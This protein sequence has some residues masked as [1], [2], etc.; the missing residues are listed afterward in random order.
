MGSL[1]WLT[2]CAT[3]YCWASYSSRAGG[4]CCVADCCVANTGAAP[5]RYRRSLHRDGR[6]QARLEED[7]D[8]LA[9]HA[10]DLPE[11][12]SLSDL[13]GRAAATVGGGVHVQCSCGLSVMQPAELALSVS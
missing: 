13:Q 6:W 2:A 1:L 11:L 4:S 7:D 9:L 10:L 8:A 3:A 12:G 5:C